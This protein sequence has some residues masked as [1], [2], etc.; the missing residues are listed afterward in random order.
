MLTR[1]E[2]DGFKSFATFGVDLTPLMAIVGANASG[3]SNIFDALSFISRL[4]SMPLA[5]A[6]TQGRGEPDEQFR[7]LGDGSAV[8]EMRF[9]VEML[10]EPDVV[11]DFDQRETLEHT[12]LRYEVHIVEREDGRGI[13][14]PYV[15]HESIKPIPKSVDLAFQDSS[16]A[17][18]RD[19][20]KYGASQW[21]ILATEEREDRRLFL[22]R[23]KRARGAPQGRLQELPA[24]R[25]SSSVLSSITTASDYPFLFAVRREIESWRFLQLDPYAL[26]Q[27]TVSGSI[28]EHLRVNG[29]NLAWVLHLI[30]IASREDGSPGLDAVATDLARVIRGFS[31]V[32][33]RANEARGQWEVYLRTRDEG[34]VSARV[35]SDGTLRL[36]ALLAAMYEPGTPG[37]LT[38]EEPENGI[39]P[40]RLGALLQV[41][42]GLVTQPA[43]DTGG[44]PLAQLL[45]TSHSPLLLLK[46][47][48]EDLLVVDT[49]MRL[50]ANGSRIPS[51]VTRARRVLVPGD[52]VPLPVQWPAL[53]PG[54]FRSLPGILPEEARSLLEV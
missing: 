42:K 52:E 48:E 5:E 33:S 4:V 24:A 17:F 7:R 13:R 40:Q 32:E 41:L 43:D 11:D 28:D 9:A 36:L 10:L 14:R 26:R 3:K 39:N 46:V 53:G 18:K 27:P 1:L 15:W 45:M 50:E 21:K 12:R 31:A 44:Q 47:A 22:L 49:V 30:D 2:I 20:L 23:G 29:S 38:F 34:L 16:Q 6:L 8:S 54:E 35:A 25:A 19:M 37:V 51:R